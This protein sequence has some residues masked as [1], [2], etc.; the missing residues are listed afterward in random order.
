MNKPSISLLILISAVFITSCNNPKGRAVETSEAQEVA[1]TTSSF[2]FALL[3]DQSTI[4][5]IGSKPTGQ[6]DG[7]IPVSTGSFAIDGDKLVGGSFT[8]DM[9]GV[10]VNDLEKGSKG[11]E[12][13]KKHLKSDD[14]FG[15]DTYPIAKFEITAV[16]PFDKSIIKDKEEFKTA[17]TPA[18]ASE[19]VVNNPTHNISGNL[20]MKGVTKN[21]TF[22]A[23]VTISESNL[24]ALAKFNIDRTDWNLTYGDE[25]SA[26]DKAKDKFIYNTVNIALEVSA[27]GTTM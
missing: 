10:E 15:T 25:S 27:S 19:Y 22:P 5:W 2:N 6:H 9:N 23:A 18:T 26:V 13:L 14:F 12:K 7:T 8:L 1:T 16:T 11:Y 17:Y 3:P 20:T 4:S 24:S 21:I